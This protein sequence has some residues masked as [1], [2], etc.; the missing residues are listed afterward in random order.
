M[1]RKR[2]ISAVIGLIALLIT[3]A[4]AQTPTGQ[5]DGAA[6]AVQNNWRGSAL[7]GTRFSTPTDS[8]SPPWSTY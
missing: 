4:A 5:G 3:S 7:I 6:P 1:N 8:A 2:S